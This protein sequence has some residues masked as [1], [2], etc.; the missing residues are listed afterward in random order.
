[1]RKRLLGI[2]VVVFLMVPATALAK[3]F[4]AGASVGRSTAEVDAIN[5]DE[6]DGGFKVFGGYRFHR[7]FSVEVA[8]ADF[9]EIGS[10][11]QPGWSSVEVY[12]IGLGILGIIPLNERFDVYGKVG[13]LFWDADLNTNV[14]GPI[15]TVSDDGSDL[16]YAF[17]L[18]YRLSERFAL[19]VEYEAYNVDFGELNL[20]TLGA[21]YTF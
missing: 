3:D 18:A 4:Y 5:F 16:S 12:G 19:R 9:K 1:M 6:S 7:D 2:V 14:G 8:Y 20:A 13:I 11:E 21:T 15:V 10:A 17:G